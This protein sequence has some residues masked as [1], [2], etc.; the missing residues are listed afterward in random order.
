MKHFKN[1]LLLCL[2]AGGLYGAGPTFGDMAVLL[3]KGYFGDHVPADASLAQCVRFLNR[4]GICFSLFD[5]I[6]PEKIVKQEDLAR[7]M[8]Q[9]VLLFSGEAEIVN[10]CIKKP[11]EAETWVDYCLLN[12]VPL[13]HV[14][15]GLVE[16]T[17]EGSLP[18][19]RQFFKRSS[20]NY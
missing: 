13:L 5:L 9:A 7:V 15:N 19:V 12:D 6:D 10:G 8:G 1:I 16:K 17:D 14:W 2:V 4:Q 20:G 18:E 3:A 11:L